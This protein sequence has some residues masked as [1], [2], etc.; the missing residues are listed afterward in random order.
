MKRTAVS[1]A[2]CLIASLWL[3]VAPG[4]VA[5]AQ[6]PTPGGVTVGPVEYVTYIPFDNS[7]STGV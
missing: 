1:L 2:A 6:T 3:G 4:G 5:S 7:T